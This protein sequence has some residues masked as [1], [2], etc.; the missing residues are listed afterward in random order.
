MR[1][2][3]F[4]YTPT[5]DRADLARRGIAG[6]LSAVLIGLVMLAALVLP[7]ITRPSAALLL[8]GVAGVFA[9]GASGS[10]VHLV[11]KDVRGRVR[12]RRP[13]TPH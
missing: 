13:L 12:L 10:L 5:P 11:I 2:T 8:T 6:I 7:A 3:N 1:R 9:L 4:I